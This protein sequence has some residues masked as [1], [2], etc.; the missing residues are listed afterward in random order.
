M[1]SSSWLLKKL[2][3]NDFEN[4]RNARDGP[5]KFKFKYTQR[6]SQFPG[7]RRITDQIVSE[8]KLCRM[9]LAREGL[10]NECGGCCWCV[11]LMV[12]GVEFCVVEAVRAA[13]QN[14]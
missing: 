11:V 12:C 4:P 7:R 5:I 9:E 2:G 3:C 8:P 14:V 13:N 10:K 1:S 6:L